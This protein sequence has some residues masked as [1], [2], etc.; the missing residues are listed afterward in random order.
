MH[1]IKTCMLVTLCT[2]TSLSYANEIPNISFGNVAEKLEYD[3]ATW[4]TRDNAVRSVRNWSCVWSVLSLAAFIG[5]QYTNPEFYYEI[6]RN[7]TTTPPDVIVTTVKAMCFFSPIFFTSW[8]ASQYTNAQV[9][10]L[11]RAVQE[12]IKKSEQQNK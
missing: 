7:P 8:A 10:E 9:S 1:K 6:R 4:K 11:E 5:T 3:L 12:Y 2:I